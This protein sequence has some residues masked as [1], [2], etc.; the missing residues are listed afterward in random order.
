MFPFLVFS[1]KG[2]LAEADKKYN[3]FEYIK[4]IK[5]Y[6]NLVKKGHGTPEI[7]EKLA[8]IYYD[9]AFYIQANNWYSKLYELNP[10]M[11]SE[12]HYRYA[13]TLKS[14]ANFDESEK[15]LKLFELASPNQ[16]RTKL[17]KYK[18]LQQPIFSFSNLKSLSINSDASD[19]GV[20]FRGDTLIFSS[21][22]GQILSDKSSPRTGQY[23]TNL[24][25]TV[26]EKDGEYSSPK[27]F[28]LSSYSVYNESTPVFSSDGNL[29]FYTQNFI[30]KGYK[31]KLVNEGFKLYKSVLKN[32]I[33]ESTECVTF[34]QKDSIKI[35]HPSLSP[36]GKFLYFASNMPGTF[37]DSDLFRIAITQEGDFGKIEHLSDK[38]NTEGRE[39]F[40]H[41]TNK[42][43]LIFASNGH[44]G[45]GGLDLYSIDLSDPNAG[46]IS[47][48]PDVNSAF[49]DFA[50]V[51][52]TDLTKGY[53]TSNRPGGLGNDDIYSLDAKEIQ[54]DKVILPSISKIDIKGVIKDEVSNEAMANVSIALTDRANVEI[55]KTKTDENGSYTFNGVNPNSD[56]TLK[57]TKYDKIV[58]LIP[59]SVLDKDLYTAI[60]TSKNLV[61]PN[62]DITKISTKL[63]KDLAKDLKI[64]QIY[65]DFNK[66]DIR[67]DAQLDLDNLVAFMNL[68]PSIR[69]EIGSHTDSVGSS[70]SNLLLSQNRADATLNYIVAQGVDSSRLSS[71]GYGESRL[72]NNCTNGVKCTKEEHQKNRRSTFVII[73]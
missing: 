37:G 35:A 56:Y 43:I 44:P 36:D 5:I 18:N 9:N 59:I 73:N 40:P 52:S 50:M 42:N 67:P 54:I 7:I 14:I 58:R 4:A 29:M 23:H 34:S 39:S 26:K 32:R 64:D 70:V 48:G 22:R 27:L 21:A 2:A 1:Q 55:A 30:D 31:N 57:L 61:I 3:N 63:G 38:I 11:K 49:D 66:F 41:I 17:L 71:V 24:Y 46:V 65:F 8:T 15:Q 13:Q 28:S 33:W 72:V 68:N 53:F 62:I 10:I 25:K 69:I 12:N 19:Y 20:F 6:E 47:L 16:I 45:M 51:L 60:I